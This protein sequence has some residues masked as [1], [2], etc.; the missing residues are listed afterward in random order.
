VS[1]KGTYTFNEKNYD[2]VCNIGIIRSVSNCLHSVDC[3]PPS[4]YEVQYLK[5]S[6]VILLVCKLKP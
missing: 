2:Y 5:T 3:G 4:Y 6:N 1:G